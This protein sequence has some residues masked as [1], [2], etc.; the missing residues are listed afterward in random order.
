[1]PEPDYKRPFDAEDFRGYFT[2]ESRLSK[3]LGGGLF[4]AC[5]FNELEEVLNDEQLG[6]RSHWS[7]NHPEFDLWSAP[8]V[9]CGLNWYHKGNKYGPVVLS[10]PIAMLEGRTFMV[11]RRRGDTRLRYFFVQYEANIPIFSR[12][13][14][15]WRRVNPTTYFDSDAN[16]SEL[17]LKSGAIYDI[18][19]TVPLPLLSV[20]IEA[21]SHPSCISDKCEGVS[22]QDSCSDLRKI[23]KKRLRQLLCSDT[24]YRAFIERFPDM[25]GVPVRLPRVLE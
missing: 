17:H 23:G 15:P 4:H 7:L 8:G 11:F 24:A 21:V 16:S 12:E 5:H 9:W 10:F 19:I 20:Q 6:L 18:V 1:M 14:K 22:K 25:E 3:R 13:G 2:W